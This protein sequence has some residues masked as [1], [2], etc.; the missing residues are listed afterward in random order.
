MVY[1]HR[2]GGCYETNTSFY[3]LVQALGFDVTLHQGRLLLGPRATPP[4]HHM[5]MTVKFD[6]GTWIADVGFGKGGRYPIPHGLD[7]PWTDPHGVFTTKLLDDGSTDV[8]RNGISLYRFSDEP[9][10]PR[11]FRQTMWWYQ[12]NPRSPFLQ[13]LFCFLPLENG[14]VSLRDDELIVARG[15]EKTTE[16]L[17]DDAAV[18]EAYEK[19]FGIRLD[20]RPV[21]SRYNNNSLRFAL[22]DD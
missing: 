20:K 9:A 19:W 17:A 8:V 1:Q 16:L 13:N 3:L 7:E 18:L 2:G 5:M 4:Y 11:D 22:D 6:T 12:T 10:E 21:P 14:W 15:T